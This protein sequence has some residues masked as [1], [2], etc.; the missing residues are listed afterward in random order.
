MEY[1][2]DIPEFNFSLK[3]KQIFNFLSFTEV[4]NLDL[5]NDSLSPT[6]YM[7]STRYLRTKGLCAAV[8]VQNHHFTG[9]E[10]PCLSSVKIL[11]HS[12]WDTRKRGQYSNWV[13][14]W[15]VRGSNA[16]RGKEISSPISPEPPS[17]PST[18]T[19]VVCRR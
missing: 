7:G 15:M 19:T 5:K 14:G 12:L 18:G 8:G 1:I 13:T 3:L 17:P 10:S 6:F 16:G 9:K 11:E 2:Q 4:Y